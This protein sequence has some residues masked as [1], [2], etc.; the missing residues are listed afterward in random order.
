MISTTDHTPH[1][2]IRRTISVGVLIFISFGILAAVVYW[3]GIA[4]TW[5]ALGEVG[6]ASFG[7]LGL[8]AGL[9][10]LLQTLAWLI[11]TRSLRRPVR[12]GVLF[13]ATLVGLAVN[14]LTPSSYLGG[15]PVKVV[16]AGRRTGYS[17]RDMAGTVV[18]CKYL[19]ALS[20][21]LFFG[22]ST[23]I[24]TVSFSDILFEGG[25]LLSL[26]SVL[27]LV[28]A[29]LILL[30][31]VL[32]LGMSRN[33]RPLYRLVGLLAAIWPAAIWPHPAFWSRLR[34][35]AG[36]MEARI[37]IIFL[38]S[39][40]K[41]FGA[42]CLLAAT[43]ATFFVKP[44]IFLYLGIGLGLDLGE[45]SLIF[46][47]SQA[48]LALQLTPSGA[49]TLDGGLIGIFLLLGISEVHCMALLLCLRFWDAVAVGMG[50]LICTRTGASMF[51]IDK[52]RNTADK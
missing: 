23:A 47:A 22:C 52:D 18:L 36:R 50:A 10:L 7:A 12:F 8:L 41:A 6:L 37:S 13:E 30:C 17:Y 44:A 20:F 38:R 32:W 21:L 28:T 48:L 49:G 19:E 5:E 33:W 26:G 14:I 25:S 46:V 35:N 39:P 43:H 24:A 42:F 31:V 45:L 51:S 3:V 15:E 4:E 16:F 29:A 11:L 40:L 2:T 9:V 27:I 1:S 34:E